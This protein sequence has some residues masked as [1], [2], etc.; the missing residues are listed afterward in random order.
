MF[1][2]PADRWPKHPKSQARAALEEARAAGWWFAPSERGHNFGRL[3]CL[4]PER[5]PDGDACKV[6]IFS[7]AG[8]GDGSDTALVIR[9]AVRKCPHDRGAVADNGPDPEVAARLAAGKLAQLS[10]LVE[11][12]EALLAKESADR[13]A[14]EVVEG[15]LRELEHDGATRTD[16]LDNVVAELERLASGFDGRA[17]AAASRAGAADPWPPHEGAWEVY[18]LAQTAFGEA[19]VL[20]NAAAGAEDERRVEAE[21][22]RLEVRLGRVSSLL[23]THR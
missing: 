13:K 18:R 10:A 8:A 14:N 23:E 19:V 20:V 6:P 17:R 11:A 7:T 1:L 16:H 15:A 3:R 22:D 21:R 4:P 2:G 9:D 5:D 12:A